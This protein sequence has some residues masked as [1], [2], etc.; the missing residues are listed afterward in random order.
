MGG[1]T[2]EILSTI[3]RA[4]YEMDHFW[5]EFQTAA[6]FGFFPL[7]FVIFLVLMIVQIRKVR[8]TGAR[9][10]KAIVF[11]VLAGVC[12]VISLGELFLVILLS[13]EVAHM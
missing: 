10:V 5:Y 13:I 2:M 6:M 8:K 1:I 11:G 4:S 12:A 3:I 9:K 7:L